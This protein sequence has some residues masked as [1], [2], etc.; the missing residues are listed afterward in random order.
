MFDHSL[1]LLF[2]L[3]Y[4]F[5]LVVVCMM[6]HELG[7]ILAARYYHVKIKE[8]GVNRMGMYIRR[9]RTTGWPEISVCLAGALMNLT[10]AIAFWHVNYWF[11]LCNLVLCIVNILPIPHS[12]GSH[13]LGAWIKMQ[14]QAKAQHELAMR[15][16]GIRD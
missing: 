2:S 12:D 6:A 1:A 10:L 11:A 5:A 8:L 3:T 15:L 13:A 4:K 7:H 16:I 14:L 9:A